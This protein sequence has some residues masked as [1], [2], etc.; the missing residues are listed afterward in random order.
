MNTP[1]NFKIGKL[2]TEKGYPNLEESNIPYYYKSNNLS[3]T[4]P[5]YDTAG[6]MVNINMP[7]VAISKGYCYALTIAEV[8][9]WLHETHG[10]WIW[11]EHYETESKFIPQ[12]PKGKL[13]KVLGYYNSPTEAYTSV[14]L[15]TLN[16][17]I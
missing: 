10:I 7:E 16:N 8:V 14:I 5:M 15:Y 12:I 4:T 3:L 13:E 9:M 2:L 6:N 17:L 11:V 1:V